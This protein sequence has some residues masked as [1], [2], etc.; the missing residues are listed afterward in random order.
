MYPEFLYFMGIFP[1]P[2]KVKNIPADLN[3]LKYLSS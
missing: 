2:A 1:L 3:L